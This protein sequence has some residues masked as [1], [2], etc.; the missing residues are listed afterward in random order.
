VGGLFLFFLA[1]IFIGMALT[2][3]PMVMGTPRSD[4]EVTDYRDQLLTV[5]PP[6]VTILVILWLGVWPPEPLLQLLRDGAAM[7]EVRP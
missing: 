7:L 1:S 5:G 4:L 6:L 3:L 2:V